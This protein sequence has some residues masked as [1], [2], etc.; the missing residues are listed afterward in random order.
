[1]AM[2]YH[3]GDQCNIVDQI[4]GKISTIL[5]PLAAHVENGVST[6]ETGTV[7]APIINNITNP[8]SQVNNI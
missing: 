3:R 7:V 2:E 5:S 8:V 4:Q 6:K 1:M